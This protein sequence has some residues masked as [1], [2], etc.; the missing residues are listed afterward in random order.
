MKNNI[1]LEKEHNEATVTF[2][3]KY[4]KV[5][6]SSPNSILIGYYSDIKLHDLKAY[7]YNMAEEELVLKSSFYQIIKYESGYIWEI[8]EGGE[9]K[10][11]L[12]S[13]ISLL[14]THEDV[15]IETSKRNIKIKKKDNGLGIV[16][17]FLNESDN[18]TQTPGIYFSDKMK[19]LKSTGY[20]FYKFGKSILFAGI[21]CIFL[22]YTFKYVVFNKERMISHSAINIELPISKIEQIKK[23][24]ASDN[25]FIESIVYKNKKWEIIESSTKKAIPNKKNRP[26]NK[27]TIGIEK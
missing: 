22:S 1:T 18:S 27:G 6:I 23:I 9:G 14:E 10:G 2:D 5:E 20:P 4:S 7:L 15:I 21:F 24:N 13:L 3:E 8:Q 12:K 16:S 11:V 19:R 25:N 26:D 17:Y